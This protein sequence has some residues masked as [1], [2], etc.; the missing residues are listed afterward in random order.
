MRTRY[1]LHG[2]VLIALAL[3]TVGLLS[4]WPRSGAKAQ[5]A[6]GSTQ[7]TQV[8]TRDTLRSS[9]NDVGRD[10]VAAAL[11]QS[12]QQADSQETDPVLKGAIEQALANPS[13]LGDAT[14]QVT[15]SLSGGDQSATVPVYTVDALG[16]TIAVLN[17]QV[18]R[19]SPESGE[20]HPTKH[21]DLRSYINNQLA[22]DVGDAVL[23]TSRA[24]T[25]S[26]SKAADQSSKILS[27]ASS[28]ANTSYDVAT[29]RG[30]SGDQ[31]A[32]ATYAVQQTDQ[33]VLQSLGALGPAPIQSATT[34]APGV[35]IVSPPDGTSSLV[36]C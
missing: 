12:L 23:S 14:D 20:A 2:I 24:K 30:Q 17:L 34:N 9:V 7:T 15:R 32:A 5:V 4:A 3:A 28:T 25:S 35:C 18:T 11:K 22:K 33:Q 29:N 6:P 31:Q 10:S 21:D 19:I 26:L 1:R 8:K 16:G 36:P 27:D 13:A